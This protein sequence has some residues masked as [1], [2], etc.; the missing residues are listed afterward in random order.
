M[1]SFMAIQNYMSRFIP[2]SIVICEPM[3]KLLNKDVST[4]WTNKCQKAFDRIKEYLSNTQVLVLPMVGMPFLLYLYV[5]D[6]HLG[7]Y[8]GSMIK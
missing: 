2:Q 8:W 7:V 5:M 6:N 4:K 3:F 1:I